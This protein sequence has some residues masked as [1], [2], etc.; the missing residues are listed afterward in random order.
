MWLLIKSTRSYKF[1]IVFKFLASSED[2]ALKIYGAA[3]FMDQQM[4][5]RGLESDIIGK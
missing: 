5:Q 3:Q 2:E 1:I 4:P